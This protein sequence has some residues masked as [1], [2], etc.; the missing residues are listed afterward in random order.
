MTKT[1]TPMLCCSP[2]MKL[3]LLFVITLEEKRDSGC[4]KAKN[5]VEAEMTNAFQK[6][7]AESKSYPFDSY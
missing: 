1:E 4:C 6:E 7:R 3:R 2:T 5:V